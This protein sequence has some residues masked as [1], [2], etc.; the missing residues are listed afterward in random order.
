M[1][2]FLTAIGDFLNGLDSV[3]ALPIVIA[4]LGIVLGPKMG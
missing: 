1:E 2:G 3:I 4:I